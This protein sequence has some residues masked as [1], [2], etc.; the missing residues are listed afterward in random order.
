MLLLPVNR[1]R[2]FLRGA[3]ASAP[4]GV[5][6]SA[7]EE[8]LSTKWALDDFE[9]WLAAGLTA[10][11]DVPSAPASIPGPR[12]EAE[13]TPIDASAFLRPIGDDEIPFEHESAGAGPDE[14][15]EK[16]LKNQ[17]P[18]PEAG[19]GFAR[20][21]IDRAPRFAVTLQ[22]RGR[23][24]HDFR[25]TTIDVSRA[26]VQF[27]AAGPFIPGEP[28]RLVVA[29]PQGT[30]TE[31]HG[32]IVWARRVPDTTVE[33]VAGARLG[34]VPPEFLELVRDLSVRR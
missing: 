12:P 8:V 4:R 15:T 29:L 13:V 31:L 18:P 19:R 17:L 23:T 26:G 10:P 16:L 20:P 34:R 22:I 25:G 21:M 27:R 32:S 30:I 9:S 14:I 7:R 5:S 24:Q 11:V 28:I 6:V 33:F 2:R 3:L 1:Q